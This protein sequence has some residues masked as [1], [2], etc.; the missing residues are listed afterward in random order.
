MKSLQFKTLIPHIVALLIFLV[1]AVGYFSPPLLEGKKLKQ[2]DIVTGKAMQKEIVDYR[3]ANGEE[4][5]WTNSM[6]SGMPAYQISVRYFSGFINSVRSVFELWLP[7]P[8]DHLMLYMIGF[9]LLL[10]VLGVSPWLSIAG[11]IAF[12]LSSYF[13]IIIGAGHIWK[14]RTIAFL[15]PTLAGIILTYRGQLLKGGIITAVFLTFQVFSNHIQM[16]YYFMMMVGIMSLFELYYRVQEKE[17]AAF[18]KSVAVLLAASVIALGVNITNIATTYEYGE[19]T[20][21][22]KSE[23]TFNEANKTS[24]L[25]RDY[26]TGWSYGIAES[27]SFLIPNAKGGGSAYLGTNKAA[28]EKV[29]PG[30]RET[31][32]NNSH[33][34]GDQPGTSGPVYMGAII[35]FL[36]ILGMFIVE[37]RYKWALFVAAVLV[38]MLSWGKN[39]MGLTDLFLDYFPLYNK[40][41]TVSSILIIAELIFPIIAF[42][43]LKKIWEE[44]DIIIKKAKQFYISLGLSGGIAFI[45]YLMPNLFFDF[46]NAQEAAQ[47]QDYRMQNPGSAS[48]MEAYIRNLEIARVAIF[49]A[50]ALRSFLFIAVAALVLWFY[51]KK[52]LSKTL[53][54]VSISLLMIIDLGVIDKRYMNNDEFVSKRDVEVPVRPT[55]A[56]KQILKDKDPNF[57]V[58]NL[59]VNTFNEATTSYFHKSIGGYHG[60][61]L[62]RYQELIEYQISK[63]NIGVLNMLNTKY[64]ITPNDQ[65]V[66]VA[67]QN[68]GALGN[69]WFVNSFDWVNNA[70]EEIMALTD[71]NPANK[72]VVDIRFEDQ[73]NGF[74][75]QADSMA[76]IQLT[77][78]QPNHLVYASSAKKDGLAVFSEIYYPKG[79]DAYIDGKPVP[80]FRAN[81]VLR[82]MIIPAGEHQIEFKFEPKS[83]YVSEKISMASSIILGLI[84]L[85]GLFVM[86]RKKE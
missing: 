61:K 23:L 34:W 54:A 84:L 48:Q 67:Q 72:A 9:Y 52:K 64:I 44:P 27:W 51:S 3:E 77:S 31:I 42:L 28:M 56:D 39:F 18:F 79:W 71:L 25:D 83:Y 11:A 75:A 22:G 1:V 37:W 19:Y 78:Y 65:R 38:I 47:F 30:Y 40:F 2:H 14:V 59:A 13:L 62:Q 58:L 10:I 4:A 73:L 82:A 26:V 53:L 36:M 45:F 21:R 76:K 35:F 29:D 33:Y 50:D 74:T 66:P 5:L 81:Y 32:A 41:R 15:A 60:A 85:G 20:I 55:P 16:T 57:R 68:P 17:L 46:I 7:S 24:G 8:A 49:K 43:A 6:F 12:A 63:N 70:N 69:A 80:H 86:F